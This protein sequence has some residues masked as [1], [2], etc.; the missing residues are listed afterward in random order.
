MNN[1]IVSTK[2]IAIF[3]ATVLVLGTFAAIS[4]SS[5]NV[6]AEAQAESE[7]YGI[8]NR[9]NSYGPEAEYPPQYPQKEYNSYEHEIEYGKD[10][11]E[12]PSYRNDYYEQPK[13]YPSYKPDYKP[14]Y[15]SYEKDNKYKSKDSNSVSINKLNC[16][17]N[18][19][20]INGNNAGNVSIGNK[21]QGYLDSYSFGGG[22]YGEGFNNKQGKGFDCIINN[23]NNNTNVV[24]GGDGIVTIP[25]PQTCEE[26]FT[27]NLNETQIQALEEAITRTGGGVLFT[28]EDFCEGF[29]MSPNVEN[30][31]KLEVLDLR[32][33][34][35]GI[36]D[37]IQQLIIECLEDLEIIEPETPQP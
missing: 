16:I 30:S 36:S 11:Y 27:F 8:D 7:Y 13:E 18:N 10:S 4:P 20:N 22:Y 2:S 1:K 28:I 29:L 33:D 12:K 9:Y 32:L 5:F 6:G 15:P 31:F 37:V 19:V 34:E 23:N 26:C 35:S 17:N 21:G 3:L 25:E 14:E 24:T